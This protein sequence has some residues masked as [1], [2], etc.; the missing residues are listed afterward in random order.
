MLS[1]K[2]TGV[3]GSLLKDPSRGGALFLQQLL[4]LSFQSGRWGSPR[5]LLIHSFINSTNIY[6]VPAMHLAL[7]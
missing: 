7:F 4:L 3:E 6:G 1:R 5:S 2:E